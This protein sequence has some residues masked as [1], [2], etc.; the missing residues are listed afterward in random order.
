MTRVGLPL[1]RWLKD[2]LMGNTPTRE[3]T[4]SFC[5]FTWAKRIFRKTKL[6]SLA[7]FELGSFRKTKIMKGP[8]TM[9]KRDWVLEVDPR[10]V[11][12]SRTPKFLCSRYYGSRADVNGYVERRTDETSTLHS[13]LIRKLC[14]LCNSTIFR[15][16]N[17]QIV[18][19][20]NSLYFSVPSI[21]TRTPFPLYLSWTTPLRYFV[22]EC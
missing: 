19:L 20:G 21:C 5:K 16:L 2:Q 15:K 6:S 13:R 1:K 17:L 4:S 3:G 10:T 12:R 9:R 8:E 7:D 14:S 18:I 11:P 22:W